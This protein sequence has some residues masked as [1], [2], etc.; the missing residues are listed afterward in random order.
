M[1]LRL[2]HVDCSISKYSGT[3][4]ARAARARSCAA[5]P[6]RSR[7]RGRSRGVV[8]VATRRHAASFT[9]WSGRAARAVSAS[10]RPLAVSSSA[11]APSISS[12][13]AA[14]SAAR[15]ITSSQ[16][17]SRSTSR[18]GE[19]DRAVEQA[20]EHVGVRLRR[21]EPRERLHELQLR[22]GARSRRA[23]RAP[24]RRRRSRRRAARGAR[25]RGS[26]RR[27]ARAGRGRGR[28][29]RTGSRGRRCR[30]RGARS[31]SRAA[32]RRARRPTPTR[33]RRRA[34]RDRRAR[35]AGRRPCANDRVVEPHLGVGEVVVVHEQQVGPREARRARA[36]RSTRRRC[37]APRGGCARARRRASLE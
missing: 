12:S 11:S 35:R 33:A 13:D 31:R 32:R 20:A 36:R 21:G 15:A 25:R 16:R 2:A 22:V 5:I 28:G 3:R 18:P 14:P 1:K 29:P 19:L 8:S 34:P 9:A 4:R 6:R 7:G 10:W 24:T 27:R 26:G 37:R 30:A 17:R 23:R